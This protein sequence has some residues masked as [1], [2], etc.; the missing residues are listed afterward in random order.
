MSGGYFEYKQYALDDIISSID[1]IISDIEQPD[2]DDFIYD[3][4]NPKTIVEFRNALNI[5]KRASVYI[6]RIDWL[7]SGDDSEETFHERLGVDMREEG[8]E[9]YNDESR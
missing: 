3:I 1:Q 8:L 9:K 6:R 2:E 7:L 4:K 5:C